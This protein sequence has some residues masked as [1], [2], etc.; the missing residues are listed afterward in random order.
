[1]KLHSALQASVRVGS[2]VVAV[3]ALSS[4]ALVTLSPGPPVFSGGVS[5]W[6]LPSLAWET[7]RSTRPWQYPHAWGKPLNPGM[8]D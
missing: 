3:A 6:M 7:R 1:M 8:W 2:E 4:L 5:H